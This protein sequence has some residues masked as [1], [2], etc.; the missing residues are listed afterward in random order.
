MAWEKRRAYGYSRRRVGAVLPAYLVVG[1]WPLVALA[2]L[3]LKPLQQSNDRSNPLARQEDAI[4]RMRLCASLQL[5]NRFISQSVGA[6]LKSRQP[7]YRSPTTLRR[8]IQCM[9]EEDF[10]PGDSE[11]PMSGMVGDMDFARLQEV[12]SLAAVSTAWMAHVQQLQ[13]QDDEIQIEKES[14]LRTSFPPGWA[15]WVRWANKKDQIQKEVVLL[16]TL[17]KGTENAGGPEEQRQRLLTQLAELTK[18]N[19]VETLVKR[20]NKKTMAMYKSRSGG[21]DDK[22]E[23]DSPSE[24]SNGRRGQ[25]GK[26][27]GPWISGWWITRGGPSTRPHVVHVTPGLHSYEARAYSVDQITRKFGAISSS[28]ILAQIQGEDEELFRALDTAPT[29]PYFGVLDIGPTDLGLLTYDGADEIKGILADDF[30]SDIIE[31]R[32]T[33]VEPIGRPNVDISMPGIDI[34]GKPDIDIIGRSDVDVFSQPGKNLDIEIVGGPTGMDT[35][36]LNGIYDLKSS[37]GGKSKRR[38]KWSRMER[39]E[40]LDEHSP[41]MQ[42]ASLQIVGI[43]AQSADPDGIQGQILWQ[44][45]LKEE[46]SLRSTPGQENSKSKFKRRLVQQGMALAGCMAALSAKGRCPPDMQ[47]LI[48]VLPDGQT[49]DLTGTSMGPQMELLGGDHMQKAIEGYGRGLRLEQLDWSATS[50]LIPFELDLGPVTALLLLANGSINRNS[51]PFPSSEW[52]LKGVIFASDCKYTPAQILRTKPDE[53]VLSVEPRWPHVTAE[54]VK[55]K[56]S[57]LI[58]K[59]PEEGRNANGLLER[60]NGDQRATSVSGI[61]PGPHDA[62][63][64]GMTWSSETLGDSFVEEEVNLNVESAEELVSK[65]DLVKAVESLDAELIANLANLWTE[66]TGAIRYQKLNVPQ[67]SEAKDVFEGFFAGVFGGNHELVQLRK[68]QDPKSGRIIIEGTKIAG[69]GRLPIGEAFF[70]AHGEGR[71][72]KDSGRRYG[73]RSKRLRPDEPPFDQIGVKER[74]SASYRTEDQN[75]VDCE[76]LVLEDD[77]PARMNGCA[78]AIFVPPGKGEISGAEGILS[79]G[80]LMTLYEVILPS[81]GDFPQCTKET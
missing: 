42:E 61:F 12:Q 62:L 70:T 17:L 48:V 36:F 43:A 71:G 22:R 3:L 31:D 75:W 28:K 6:T 74:Y 69:D 44:M 35:S 32:P 78:L 66:D 33:E 34:V 64:D 8:S 58:L 14:S 39:E 57:D 79:G 59:D 37:D 29:I 16:Q 77:S 38:K 21:R 80:T 53:I 50:D 18:S 9:S 67:N 1:Y 49:H 4:P 73:T 20:I 46:R 23:S 56:L 60:G 2:L 45:L 13:D 7:C 47:P 65:E 27:I 5:A 51:N 72:R 54:F 25:M 41:E 26:G 19:A 63:D 81:E 68:L 24:E 55:K 11:F 52:K 30:G 10:L 40:E 15:E 76:L